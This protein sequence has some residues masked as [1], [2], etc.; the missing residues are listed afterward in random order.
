MFVSGNYAYVASQYDN[1]LSIIDISNPASPVLKSQVYDGDGE[2]SKLA[3]AWSVY[4]SGSYAYVASVLDSSLT[5]MD[6]S[7][8]LDPVKK[9]EVYHVDGEFNRLQAAWSVYVSGN[10]AYVVSLDSNSLTVMDI[11][12]PTN[13]IKK[14]E[15][16][17]GDGEFN[18]M[19][20]AS[21]V[22]VSGN[23][24]YVTAYHDNSLTIMDISNPL[25]PVKKSEVYDGD[26]EFTK[27]ERAR[28]VYVSGN[29]A[30]VASELDNSLTIMDISDPTNPVKKA[31]VYD[32][33]GE[34]ERLREANG[35]FVSGNYAYVTGSFDKGVTVMDISDP[36]N[37]VKKAE[38]YDGDG[39]FTKLYYPFGVFVSGNYVYV[40]SFDPESTT[41]GIASLTIMEATVSAGN[42]TNT[43]TSNVRLP[44]VQTVYMG[45]DLT[46][47]SVSVIWTT[48]IS[49]Y[50]QI[51]YGT[52]SG[53]YPQKTVLNDVL[54]SFHTMT[55]SGLTP[56]TK[57]YFRVIAGQAL[58]QKAYS[59]EYSFTTKPAAIS[60]GAP[61]Q[62]ADG[63]Y[64]GSPATISTTS[65]Q[66]A[67]SSPSTPQSSAT[68]TP[69]I[70]LEDNDTPLATTT[71]P[72]ETPEKP[73]APT[74]PDLPV[75]PAQ[76][77][78]QA[79]AAVV[80]PVFNRDLEIGS[81][82]DDTKALQEFL[83]RDPLLYPERLVTGFFGTLTQKAVERFQKRHEIV[84]ATA[85]DAP[86]LGR[87]GPITRAKLNELLSVSDAMTSF[88]S[89]TS[90]ATELPSS[91]S[92]ANASI[93]TGF[94]F[95]RMLSVGST[96]ADVV[97]LQQ[98]LLAKGFLVLNARTTLGYFG[99]LSRAAVIQLQ[100]SLGLEPVGVVG[101]MTRKAL[102]QMTGAL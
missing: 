94:L 58:D 34:F 37:P 48:D 75:V 96:G 68:S 33:D 49:S 56:D 6:I 64:I 97:A 81:S 53:A 20:G 69:D 7:N 85:T 11:S 9:S 25:D 101:P 78:T 24:A 80:S 63:S 26:G 27:L 29:Y 77:P 40:T 84:P 42:Q 95:A 4:V 76:L 44:Y 79:Q 99:G 38:A 19:G 59:S 70:P 61:L 36:T 14:S 67:T 12:D 66:T 98:I 54:D 87:V 92:P 90:P 15:V 71:P 82:G 50:S 32:S 28:S 57:Y 47:T 22:Y 21:S 102:N 45:N 8:P 73:A 39:T 51:E 62:T 3:G 65:P 55:L 17:S 52:T 1:S 23:Y 41:S 60:V 30:Y 88:P 83:A 74:I 18:R 93:P 46:S 16:Y 43:I 72:A 10:Y 89:S 31:E 91:V 5:I 86:G 13:P 2:F 100:K 35:V